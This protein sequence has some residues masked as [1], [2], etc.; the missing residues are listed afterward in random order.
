MKTANG[1]LAILRAICGKAVKAN[2]LMELMEDMKQYC[3][4]VDAMSEKVSLVLKRMTLLFKVPFGTLLSYENIDA[5]AIGR[6]VTTADGGLAIL[7]AICGKA[8]KA[9]RLMELMEDL[10]QV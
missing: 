7:R 9:N 3:E 2:R 1:G 8:V 4:N 6:K 5:A 10:K